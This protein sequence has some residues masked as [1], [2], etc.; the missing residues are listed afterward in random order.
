MKLVTRL[1]VFF[2]SMLAAA[3]VGFSVVLYVL[4]QRHLHH[5]IRDQLDFA[6]NTLSA[7][8]E[9]E[10][11]GVE[12]EAHERRIDLP[13]SGDLPIRWCV[14][15]D[16]EELLGASLD[17]E[18]RETLLAAPRRVR[19]EEI[20]IASEPWRVA[21]RVISAPLG[22]AP[23]AATT[24]RDGKKKYPRLMIRAAIPV[25]P[26]RATLRGLAVVLAGTA[27]SLWV[28]T[29]IFG[30]RLCRRALRPV[31]VMA[32]AAKEITA[33][34]LGRRFPDSGAHD[35]LAE[36]AS[37]F[38]DL[39]ERLEESFERERRF[40]GDASHQLR[41]PLT[42]MMGQVEVALRRDR[43]AEEYQRVL[44]TVRAESNHLRQIV[45]SLLF[46]SR[47]GG[48]SEA[49]ALESLHPAEWLKEFFATWS[50]HPRF[51]DMSLQLAGDTGASVNVH[52]G[53]LGQLV[54]N[55]VD[56]ACKYSQAGSPIVI[57]LDTAG[58]F[59]ELSVE[60]SGVG[61]GDEQLPHIFEPFYRAERARLDGIEG[62]GL[63][64]SIAKRIA[65]MFGAE[66]VVRSAPG[67]G[68]VF[69]LRLP[70]VQL[71]LGQGQ[72]TFST[73]E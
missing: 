26:T 42:A 65:G 59:A 58:E 2:L 30:R 67:K 18:G 63:G 15:D 23:P 3:L 51:S 32:A 37:S 7:A 35:E 4:A 56:N 34:D 55:L 12:W 49:P 22:T 14:V 71:L 21:Q 64:L 62:T 73:R 50:N 52:G 70:Q 27:S 33:E 46:L 57:R 61:I 10:A 13:R 53:L 43:P 39:L 24:D 25:G 17:A 44:A 54:S 8:A 19:G 68:S 45:E 1:T 72:A 28:L 5:Q 16:N 9:I 40:T 29:A 31:G 6:L 47:R 48:Q 66:F 20:E 60:D 36:L 69:T 41:T 11:D 38:N